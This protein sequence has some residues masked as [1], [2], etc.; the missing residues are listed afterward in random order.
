MKSFL[1]SDHVSSGL[2]YK[3]QK[4]VFFSDFAWAIWS[5]SASKQEDWRQIA[6]AR[7]LG[8][9]EWS[10]QGI[11]F[12]GAPLKKERLIRYKLHFQGD[13]RDT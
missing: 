8:L 6:Y 10:T 2:W 4:F 1:W 13:S 11:F 3:Q 9:H 12:I 7:L 5:L